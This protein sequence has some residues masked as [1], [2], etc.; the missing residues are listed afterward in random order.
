M[1]PI[2]LFAVVAGSLIIVNDSCAE[3]AKTKNPFEIVL[4]KRVYTDAA[5]TSFMLEVECR[6]PNLR[7]LATCDLRKDQ[8]GIGKFPLR[9]IVSDTQKQNGSVKFR[10]SCLADDLIDDSFIYVQVRDLATGKSAGGVRVSL[11]DAKI[12]AI[13]DA[14][15]K[16]AA[17][18]A[19][20]KADR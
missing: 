13:E 8:Q 7:V 14:D 1:N 9:Q 6:K 20:E 17:S 18:A 4:T 3:N 11:K 5:R 10:I 12:P 16:N 19:L 15:S 2:I